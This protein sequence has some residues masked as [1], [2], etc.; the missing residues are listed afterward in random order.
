MTKTKSKVFVALSGGVDSSIAAALLKQHGFRVVGVYMKCW[1]AND[2]LYKGC[3]WIDDERSAR[4]AA[5]HL[6]IPFYT[7]NFI[8]EYRE[9][10]VE[11]L[12]DGYKNGRTPNPDVLCNREIKFGLFYEK[13][14]KLGADFVA[15]G[16]YARIGICKNS[17]SFSG[18]NFCILQG[19]DKNKDQSYF[20]AS[21]KKEVLPHVL[22]PVGN[23]T[24]LQVRELA[25]KL[26][27]P[28]ASR[29]QSKGICFIGKV[30]FN[31]FL[32]KY[33]PSRPGEIVDRKGKVLGR[34]EGLFFY[35]IGQRKGIRLSG[36]PW[37][38][39]KKDFEKNQLVVSRDENDL[40]GKD[41]LVR[42]INWFAEPSS[43]D[44]LQ[45]DVKIRYR[46]KSVPCTLFPTDESRKTYKL[47]FQEPQ[48]APTPGQF[49]V[50]YKGEEMLGG[51][52]IQ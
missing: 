17:L 45:V 40:Q 41:I 9:K 31:D 46:T 24:K 38:V 23:Y 16:H 7:W 50:F 27:L 28:N 51:G 30:D 47:V 19:V 2:P 34:H 49:A 12:L 43:K 29:M 25:K 3:T 13:A 44:P 32:K 37:Y 6:K 48:R 42:D 21:I 4:L 11:Y 14:R 18:R 36:G 26:G 22:F 15:T 10:I 20:L 52:V 8:K 33:I 39:A 1:T 35:T 5:S